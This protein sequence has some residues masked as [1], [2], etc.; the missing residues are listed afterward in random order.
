MADLFLIPQLYNAERFDVGLEAY[1]T[2]KRI[3]GNAAQTE[4]YQAS[5]P[6]RFKPE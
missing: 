4:E 1:P 2:L 5:H 6:D 3:Q